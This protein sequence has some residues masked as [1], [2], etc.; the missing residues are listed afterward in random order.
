[1]LSLEFNE[2]TLLKPGDDLNQYYNDYDGRR[3]S[4]YNYRRGDRYNNRYNRDRDRHS[5]DNQMVQAYRVGLDYGFVSERVAGRV[6]LSRPM[7][8]VRINLDKSSYR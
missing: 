6:G 4:Y 8:G 7:T 2:L 1:M 3:Q 5:Q